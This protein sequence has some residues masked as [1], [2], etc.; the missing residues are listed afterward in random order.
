[1][2]LW[3]S[4]DARSYHR[5]GDTIRTK[6]FAQNLA[7]LFDGYRRPKLAA[8]AVRERFAAKEPLLVSGGSLVAAR[9]HRRYARS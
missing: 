4:T 9:R 8:A 2:T 5:G 3:Q 1:M 6:P 7:G